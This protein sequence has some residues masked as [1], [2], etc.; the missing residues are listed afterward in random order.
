MQFKLYSRSAVPFRI[1]QKVKFEKWTKRCNVHFQVGNAF[2]G[3]IR[4][5]AR[6]GFSAG[7][8]DHVASVETDTLQS[9]FRP[10]LLKLGDVIVDENGK[11]FCFEFYGFSDMGMHERDINAE[12]LQK[13]FA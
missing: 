1:A 11:A 5:L 4:S 9:A 3:V 13:T 7:F 8:Y 12:A 2:S 6:V 10:G